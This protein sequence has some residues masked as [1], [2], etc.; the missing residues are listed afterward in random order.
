MHAAH[1]VREPLEGASCKYLLMC[2]FVLST[3][4]MSEPA[5][6]LL[7]TWQKMYCRF[8]SGFHSAF[9]RRPHPAVLYRAEAFIINVPVCI[10][11][12]CCLPG[13]VPTGLQPVPC[14]R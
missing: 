12:I 13:W 14:P 10:M 4:V 11:F 2:V 7:Y 3:A 9:L 5:A 6:A 8:G 1:A